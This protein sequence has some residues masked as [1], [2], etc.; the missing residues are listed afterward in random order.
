[1]RFFWIFP[2]TFGRSR[3]GPWSLTKRYDVA[4]REAE[5]P[6]QKRWI[7]EAWLNLAL[8]TYRNQA[9]VDG[10]PLGKLPTRT[11]LN[12]TFRRRANVVCDASA[13]ELI[14]LAAKLIEENEAAPPGDTL[15]RAAFRTGDALL[16]NSGVSVGLRQLDFG[17]SNEQAT[18]IVGIL[19][20][21]T[22]GKVKAKTGFRTP[23]RRWD[24]DQLNRWYETEGR[25]ANDEL[26]RDEAKLVLLSSHVDFIIASSNDWAQRVRQAYPKWS[27]NERTAL[28]LTAVDLENVTGYK[29]RLPLHA[30]SICDV[31]TATTLEASGNKR[32][33]RSVV[34][35]HVRRMEN[36][37]RLI[38]ARFPGLV[39]EWPCALP[40]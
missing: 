14:C 24:V 7:A 35:G 19:M 18:K 10:F 4:F 31:L 38:R 37:A 40:I 17:T 32:S 21:S 15:A 5:H 9:L 12:E 33:N 20:P 29:L 6:D 3:N 36:G 11:D 30:S 34:A 8:R 16:L 28:G 1:M 39:Y 26:S 22:L 23:V 2:A 25:K 27:D 13:K